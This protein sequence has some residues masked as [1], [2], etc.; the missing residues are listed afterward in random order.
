MNFIFRYLP[1]LCPPFFKIL[2]FQKNGTS[3]FTR[4]KNYLRTTLGCK[5]TIFRSKKFHILAEIDKRGGQNL[6]LEV[7]KNRW[8]FQLRTKIEITWSQLLRM[9]QTWFLVQNDPKVSYLTNL[10][11][12]KRG[13]KRG[14]SCG[15]QELHMLQNWYKSFNFTFPSHI[16]NVW[17]PAPPFECPPFFIFYW[18]IIKRGG[19]KG[20]LFI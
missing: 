18:H 3:L 2:I 14:G 1:P 10:L 16:S 17:A 15:S 7:G 13:G 4:I 5:L 8:F 6:S 12:L 9:I 20:G 19:K 11:N